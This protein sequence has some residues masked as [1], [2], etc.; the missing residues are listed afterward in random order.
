MP[1]ETDPTRLFLRTLFDNC[2]D[3]FV[4]LLM[5]ERDPE[6]GSAVIKL[7]VWRHVVEA[8]QLANFAARHRS[9]RDIW[10]SC[11]PRREILGGYRRGGV[12]DVLCIPALWVDLDFRHPLHAETNLPPDWLALVELQEEFCRSYEVDP[13]FVV[14]TGHGMQVWFLLKEALEVTDRRAAELMARWK[15]SWAAVLKRNGYAAPDSVYNLDR[16]LRLPGTLNLKDP[17]EPVKVELGYYDLDARVEVDLLLDRLELAPRSEHDKVVRPPVCREPGANATPWDVFNAAHDGGYVLEMLDLFEPHD[18]YAPD[19]SKNW[20]RKGSGN[21]KGATVYAD[22]HVSIWSETVKSSFPQVKTQYGYT[23]FGLLVDAFHHGDAKEAVDW[24]KRNGYNPDPI[25]PSPLHAS[26]ARLSSRRPDEPGGWGIPVGFGEFIPDMPPFPITAL[27]DWTAEQVKAVSKD[28]Q[29]P[30]DLAAMCAIGAMSAIASR[31]AKVRLGNA[32]EPPLNLYLCSVMASGDGKSPVF[33]RMTKPLWDMQAEA[34]SEQEE[35]RLK[36]ETTRAILTKRLKEA[37]DN[38]ARDPT[39]A[40]EAEAYRLA[41]EL[42]KLSVNYP[43]Q[44]IADDVT[45]EALQQVLGRQNGCIALMSDEGGM[46]DKMER[47][48]GETVNLDVYLKGHSGSQVVVNRVGRDDVFIPKAIITISVM[49]QPSVLRKFADRR[50]DELH[51]RGLFNRFL[52][53]VP[54]DIGRK[55]KHQ[56][57]RGTSETDQVWA[58]RLREMAKTP[59][60]VTFSLDR[61]ADYVWREWQQIHEDERHVGG[62]YEMIAQWLMKLWPSVGRLAGVL[63]LATDYAESGSMEISEETMRDAISIGDYWLNHAMYVWNLWAEGPIA[64]NVEAKMMLESIEK[65][66]AKIGGP[67]KVRDI[68]RTNNRRWSDPAKVKQLLVWLE[69]LGWVRTSGDIL[70]RRSAVTVEMHPDWRRHASAE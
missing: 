51:N 12:G 38:A 50:Y 3:G 45:A 30:V 23:P 67:V 54:P 48:Y 31:K 25:D 22:G 19:G 13:T 5:Q 2:D 29:T 18:D 37:Q 65:A 70:A 60:G 43:T 32:Y 66:M 26:V 35:T 62:K 64:P 6:T 15:A 36:E 8:E 16:V 27:P 44:W 53:S 61:Y 57:A 46:F 24:L 4:N 47:G 39:M 10:I 11:C 20:R 56:M 58:E 69:E 59:E 14:H 68:Q 41:E 33:E 63:H 1:Q 42:A 55:D 21:D 17:D 9:T 28:V 52:F 7:P 40:R 34:F 49:T